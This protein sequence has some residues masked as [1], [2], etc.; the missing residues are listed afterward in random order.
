MRKKHDYSA[1]LK[2]MHMLE[3]ID[4]IHT[5]YGIGSK[6]LK[7]LWLLYQ[8]EGSKVLHRQAYNR[9]DAT[10]GGQIIECSS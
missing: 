3:D 4:Y 10:F 1:L 6:R 9:S 5:K 7:K 8:K 2:Y